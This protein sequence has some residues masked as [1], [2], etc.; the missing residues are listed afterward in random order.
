MKYFWNVPVKNFIRA[1]L[2]VC[3]DKGFYTREHAFSFS[4]PVPKFI[5]I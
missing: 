1:I 5:F 2:F 3:G 4:L